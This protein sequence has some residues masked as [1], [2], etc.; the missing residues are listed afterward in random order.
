MGVDVVHHL[1]GVGSN[2]QD[3]IG[4]HQQNIFDRFLIY[5]NIY[6]PVRFM[7]K[8]NT[9]SAHILALF[10]IRKSAFMRAHNFLFALVK[11]FNQFDG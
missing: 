4:M 8:T 5:V 2:L 7:Y 3:H 9:L 1:P 10:N 11:F 6:Y